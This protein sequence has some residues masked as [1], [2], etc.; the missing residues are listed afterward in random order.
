M[1]HQYKKLMKDS[2]I[3]IEE[4]GD[5]DIPEHFDFIETLSPM[6][7]LKDLREKS[8]PPMFIRTGLRAYT[9]TCFT[10]AY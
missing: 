6:H 3:Y 5:P 2:S 7:G 9:P 10:P 8:M 4:Y 1:V